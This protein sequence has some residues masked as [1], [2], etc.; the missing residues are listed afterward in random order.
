MD[1]VL[2]NQRRFRSIKAQKTAA[3][4]QLMKL[5]MKSSGNKTL[6][7][8]EKIY[9]MVTPPK[10]TGK[11][12][13][14]IWVSKKWVLSKVADAVVDLLSAPIFNNVSEKQKV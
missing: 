7:Q 13:S 9:F 11:P 10:V 8:G 1:Q 2:V 4:V 14:D 12:A 6:P 3:Y 5:K